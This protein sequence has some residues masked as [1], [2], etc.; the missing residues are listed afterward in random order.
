M[1]RAD[2]APD[3]PSV[4]DDPCI[5]VDYRAQHRL[6]RA[7]FDAFAVATTLDV[8]SKAG[9]GMS[10]RIDGCGHSCCPGFSLDRYTL[11]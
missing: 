2:R 7:L 8:T 4:V 3:S 5:M 9:T 10:F 6:T 11:G 1:H